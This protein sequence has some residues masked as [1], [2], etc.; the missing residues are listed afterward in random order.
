[1]YIFQ[2]RLIQTNSWKNCSWKQPKIIT[3][4]KIFKQQKKKNK[5]NNSDIYFHKQACDLINW[6][7]GY[8]INSR[9]L[10]KE[11]HNDKYFKIRLTNKKKQIY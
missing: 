7:K 9:N 11:K 8:Q 4:Q 5:I 10:C 1:M 3:F 6:A 2:V